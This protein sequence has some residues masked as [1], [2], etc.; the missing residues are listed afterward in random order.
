MEK[1]FKNYK[2]YYI[3]NKTLHEQNKIKFLKELLK[4]NNEN[5][6]DFDTWYYKESMTNKQ[7]EL[8]TSGDFKKLKELL[9]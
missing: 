4:A 1:Q 3:Y 8:F 2:Q 5:K 7:Y 9:M 6:Q